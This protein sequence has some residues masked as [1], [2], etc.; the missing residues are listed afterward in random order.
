MKHIIHAMR[1]LLTAFGV[2]AA[3]GVFTSDLFAGKKEEKVCAECAVTAPEGGRAYAICVA[4]G[5]AGSEFDTC[6]RNPKECFGKNNTIRVFVTKLF[7]RDDGPYINELMY[8]VPFREGCIAVWKSGVYL[9][10]DGKNLGGEGETVN[11]WKVK[12]PHEDLIKGMVVFNDCVISAFSGGGIYKS[13]DGL[14]LGGGGNT[15]KL[16]QG[17]TITGIVVFKDCL[18]TA[19][20]TGGIY[21]SCD[22]LNP[23]GGGETTRVYQGRKVRGMTATAKGLR[24]VFDDGICY[25]DQSAERIATTRCP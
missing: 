1:Q 24:T 7:G 5:L 4:A 15:E 3:F 9:S 22:G 17:A 25:L 16:Y 23:G 8:V 13:C 6:F 2:F 18:I 10:R 19:F 20:S 12:N 14:N 21:K 11:A